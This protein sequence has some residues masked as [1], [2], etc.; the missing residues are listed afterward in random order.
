MSKRPGLARDSWTWRA[1]TGASAEPFLRGIKP[2]LRLKEA[3]CDNA[4]ALIGLQRWNKHL[5]RTT[6]PVEQL[7][8]QEHHYWLQRRLNHRGNEVFIERAMHSPRAIHRQRA[9][10]ALDM[11]R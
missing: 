10:V 8:Q 4:L 1:P 11:D 3:Q 5:G 7:Q 2:L 6:L 9:Q